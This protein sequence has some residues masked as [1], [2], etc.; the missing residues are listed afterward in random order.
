M[1]HNVQEFSYQTENLLFILDDGLET[2]GTPLTR[3]IPDKQ[4]SGG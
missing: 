2:E 1:P 3:N 4:Q